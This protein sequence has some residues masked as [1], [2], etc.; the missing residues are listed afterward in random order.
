VEWLCKTHIKVIM[1]LLEVCLETTY[2]QMD[3]FFQKKGG[4]AKRSSVSPIV[5]TIYMEHFE[6]LTFLSA[7]HTLSLWCHYNDDTLTTHTRS[8]TMAHSSYRNS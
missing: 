2:F 5:I 6:K 7:Q 8:G 1:E 3:K 4:M